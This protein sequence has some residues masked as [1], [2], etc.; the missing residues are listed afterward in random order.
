MFGGSGLAVGNAEGDGDGDGVDLLP[1]NKPACA[2]GVVAAKA[3]TVPATTMSERMRR[4]IIPYVA[5]DDALADSS[6]F[7]NSGTIAN[8]S[9][10]T[11]KSE[12]S[13]MAAEAS[14]LIATIVPAERMPTLC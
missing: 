12:N 6:S 9:P 13:P 4:F 11:S 1:P 5:Y 7:V 3:A 2:A 10:T 8:A 14:L